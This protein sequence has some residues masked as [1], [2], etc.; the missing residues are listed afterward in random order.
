MHTLLPLL[1][2]LLIS[3]THDVEMYVIFFVVFSLATLF[4]TQNAGQFT[5][6]MQGNIYTIYSTCLRRVGKITKRNF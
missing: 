1:F 6:A 4:Y 5:T 3:R 2:C